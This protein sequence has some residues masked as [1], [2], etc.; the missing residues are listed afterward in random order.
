MECP[1]CNGSGCCDCL[2][3][4]AV[5]ITQCPL[6]FINDDAWELIT[7]SELY[8]KG[9]PPIIGG[10]LDQA[11]AFVSACQFIWQENNYWKRKL[12]VD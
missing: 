4:G 8:E 5:D 2:H 6:L 9:L 3:N 1:S 11:Y 10:S 12:K 7:M